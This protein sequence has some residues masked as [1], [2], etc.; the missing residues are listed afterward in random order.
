MDSVDDLE[1][2]S[3]AKGDPEIYEVFEVLRLLDLIKDK[4]HFNPFPE[5]ESRDW[6][7]VTS[8]DSVAIPPII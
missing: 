7:T 2:S 8:G 4:P 1:E 6:W 3:I 5:P